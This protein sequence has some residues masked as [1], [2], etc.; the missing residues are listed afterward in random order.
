[1]LQLLEI[2]VYPIKSLSGISLKQ[3]QVTSRGLEL[4]RRWMLVDDSGIF[5]T[6]REY[7]QLAL[8]QVQIIDGFLLVTHSNF[9]GE[10]VKIS[11]SQK[12]DNSRVKVVVWEDEVEAILVDEG[13]SNWF[14]KILGFSVR[15]VYMPEE[16]HRKVDSKYAVSVGDITSFSD[17]FPFLIIGQTSLNDL[18]SRLDNPISIKRFR[19]NF[20]FTGGKAYEEESWKEF[21]IGSLIFYGVKPSGRCVITT[22]NPELGQFAGKEPLLTLSKYKKVE[23]KV[24]FGQNVIAKNQGILEIGQEIFVVRK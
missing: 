16:S 6:Q 10:R 2:W 17:G 21:H 14:S 5:I 8:F 7:P 22:V 11:L 1:M 23:K 4:D 12:N 3:S 19:P 9:I 15:L 13:I 20:V 18:N 24:I